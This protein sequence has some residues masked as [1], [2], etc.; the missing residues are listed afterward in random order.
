MN[1]WL[2]SL[3][4]RAHLSWKTGKHL[5]VLHVL[6]TY[7]TCSYPGYQD[8]TTY[9]PCPVP[10][11]IIE[12]LIVQKVK[13]QYERD[14]G[15]V[16]DLDQEESL[17]SFIPDLMSTYG[18]E[19]PAIRKRG[20]SFDFDFEFMKEKCVDCI[21]KTAKLV[22]G[23]QCIDWLIYNWV[24]QTCLSFYLSVLSYFCLFV[25]QSFCLFVFLFFVFLFFCHLRSLEVDSD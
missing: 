23:G 7:S 9:A 22:W 10:N 19:E 20:P 15:R 17:V 1:I 25:I 24:F 14:S 5:H 8:T 3:R 12:S 11:P 4:I 16:Q 18:W 13:C 21:R 2:S 6:R